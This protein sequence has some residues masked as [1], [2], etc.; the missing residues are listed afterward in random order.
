MRRQLPNHTFIQGSVGQAST[1]HALLEELGERKAD[2]VLSDMAP[3]CIGVKQDDHLNSAELCL[4]AS[5]L[6]EQVGITCSAC[7]CSS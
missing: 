7:G 3:A 4:H 1:L 5:D 6:M 2:V